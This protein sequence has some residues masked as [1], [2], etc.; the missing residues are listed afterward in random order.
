[1]KHQKTGD[2]V[3][4]DLDI[5]FCESCKRK[6]ILMGDK[7]ILRLRTI[8]LYCKKCKTTYLMEIR[9]L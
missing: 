6:L 3:I 1:M 5:F 8:V 4:S 2:P 9:K 7:N